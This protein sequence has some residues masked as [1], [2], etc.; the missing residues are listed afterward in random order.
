MPPY[1]LI[2]LPVALAK[3]FLK[4]IRDWINEWRNPGGLALPRRISALLSVLKRRWPITSY[5]A[6]VALMI[7]VAGVSLLFLIDQASR[8]LASWSFAAA[9]IISLLPLVPR[10][11]S[12][13]GTWAVVVAQFAVL[14]AT[15]AC[16]ARFAVHLPVLHVWA[17]CAAG[18][19]FLLTGVG[20][21]VESIH[22]EVKKRLKS[23]W[24]APRRGALVQGPNSLQVRKQLTSIEAYFSRELVVYSALP[25]GGTAGILLGLRW[26]RTPTAIAAIS[27]TCIFALAALLLLYFLVAAFR[28]MTHPTI[29]LMD[30]TALT[31][32]TEAAR[33]WASLMTEYRKMFLLD[34]V[35]NTTLLIAF[36]LQA[37]LLWH[38]HTP[39]DSGLKLVAIVIVASI[40]LNE[41]PYLVGQRRVQGALSSPFKGW[42]KVKKMREAAENIP[43]VPKLEFIAALISEASAGGLAMAMIKQIKELAGPG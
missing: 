39:I 35:Q 19:V 34:T 13:A 7:L 24:R 23:E 28:R 29:R 26:G 15:L 11:A 42:E 6:S 40:I 33:D 16:F 10:L 21:L 5:V 17:L 1:M 41:I 37:W 25:I 4:L 18:L 27:L 20:K 22:T 31:A 43:L 8:K 12:R 3:E 36:C 9:A 38:P 30:K 2:G 14:A 32:P